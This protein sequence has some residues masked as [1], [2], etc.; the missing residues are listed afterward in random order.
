MKK[1]LSLLAILALLSGGCDSLLPNGED[2]TKEYDPWD[3]SSEPDDSW[4]EI[5]DDDYPE[6]DNLEAM[7]LANI[8]AS[9]TFADTGSFIG[10][11]GTV[12]AET[13]I[14]V[15]TLPETGTWTVGLSAGK[16]DTD[17]DLFTV[18]YDTGVSPSVTPGISYSMGSGGGTVSL[19]VKKEVTLDWGH[20]SARV[21]INNGSD[22]YTKVFEFDVTLSP[23]LFKEAPR[24]YPKVDDNGKNYLDIRWEKRAT[25]TSYT[26]YVGKTDVFSAASVL[27]GTYNGSSDSA[28][29]TAF[30]GED[31]PLPND[32][33]YWVWITATNS[34]GTTPPSPAAK[35]RTTAPVPEFFWEPN[36]EDTLPIF[37]CHAGDRYRFT[38]TATNIG[39]GMTIKYWFGV[40]H[41]IG[42]IYYHEI[43]DPPSGTDNK[44]FP[45]TGKDNAV[46]TGYP[47]GVFVIKYQ[48]DHVSKWLG[49]GKPSK[50]DPTGEK[51][52]S[53]V[54]YWGMDTEKT[55]HGWAHQSYIVNQWAG[56]AETITLEEAL[57]KF[58]CARIGTYLHLMP[59]PYAQEFHRE[60]LGTNGGEPEFPY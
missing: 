8:K 48:E 34:S 39:M 57:D 42:D 56:Y 38:E 10:G 12:D 27:P 6:P 18:K 22:T 59:E 37:D 36:S 17:N 1:Y 30:P 11:A 23:P 49:G 46:C 35:K 41:Y 32:T 21:G 50:N 53:A 9:I 2:V 4:E 58:T 55:M 52:Y 47:A 28:T 3:M 51:R 20:Y 44:P 26:V 60:K 29:M 54:Y 14:T 24:V 16:G 45:N 19:A 7:Q 40:E 15:I 31:G 43:F 13:P 33:T 5:E 25:A